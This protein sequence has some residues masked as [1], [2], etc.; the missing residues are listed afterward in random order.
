MHDCGYRVWLLVA[1]GAA[2]ITSKWNLLCTSQPRWYRHG[3]IAHGRNQ[4][5]R[6]AGLFSRSC[7]RLF[8]QKFDGRAELKLTDEGSN[9]RL[10][11]CENLCF[12]LVAL[13]NNWWLHGRWEIQFLAEWLR[14]DNVISI[15]SLFST[16]HNSSSCNAAVK[17]GSRSQVWEGRQS[18]HG[19]DQE[20]TKKSFSGF[21]SHSFPLSFAIKVWPRLKSKKRGGLR[22]LRGRSTISALFPIQTL[23]LFPTELIHNSTV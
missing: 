20:Q 9:W 22:H 4:S 21:F 15:G 5:S 18:Q 7:L 10:T 12:F 1:T 16:A 19:A 8:L 14:E 6:L 17:L 11:Q 3:K 13:I 2:Y 23:I